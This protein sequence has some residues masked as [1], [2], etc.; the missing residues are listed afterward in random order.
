MYNPDTDPMKK[1]PNPDPDPVGQ[2]STDPTDSGS[3][4][5][6]ESKRNL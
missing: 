3:S 4:S 6:Y 2:K 5:L 1:L